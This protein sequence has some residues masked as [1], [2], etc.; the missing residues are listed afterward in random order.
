MKNDENQ[1]NHFHLIP[2]GYTKSW[3]SPLRLLIHFEE[4]V[5]FQI[6]YADFVRISATK[7]LIIYF[8]FF[9]A[10]PLLSI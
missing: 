5:G 7:C 6:S 10:P 4:S 9:F 2:Q 8:Q 3:I 1:K